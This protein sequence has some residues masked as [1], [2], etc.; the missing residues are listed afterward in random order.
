MP[1]CYC[2]WE[3]A[4]HVLACRALTAGQGR[5][6]PLLLLPKLC[7]ALPGSIYLVW[8]SHDTGSR[9]D[10]GRACVLRPLVEALG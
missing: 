9:V 5:S 3:L 7:T 10:R 8:R 6:H 1:H 2:R 4:C